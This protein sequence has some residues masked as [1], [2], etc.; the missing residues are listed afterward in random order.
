[1]GNRPVR[2]DNLDVIIPAC[3]TVGRPI[4][5]SV[6]ITILSFLP[7]FALSGRE[8][9]M[10]HPLAYTKTF[11]L[12]GVAVLAVTLVPRL[13]PL[14]LRGRIKSEDDSWLV[15]T[16]TE[17]FRPMLAWLMDRPTLVCW[18]F[19]CILGFGYLAS[20]RLGREFMPPLDEGTVMDM[21]T[22]VPR[23]SVAQAA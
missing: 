7:V 8:G 21:P 19:A 23:M 2:G 1:F 6:L 4:F 9:K 12:I 13:V 10:F 5:F 16:M 22:S 15:R 11:A 20:T 3:R 14:F 18:L 17:I